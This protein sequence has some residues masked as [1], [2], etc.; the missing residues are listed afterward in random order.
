MGVWFW[1]AYRLFSTSMGRS[2]IF[3]HLGPSVGKKKCTGKQSRWRDRTWGKGRVGRWKCN[4]SLGKRYLFQ[5]ETGQKSWCRLSSIISSFQRKRSIGIL[6]IKLLE[7]CKPPCADR[8]SSRICFWS[9]KEKHKSW[10]A[11][12]TVI[13]VTEQK[14][15]AAFRTAIPVRGSVPKPRN[16]LGAGDRELF[17]W[18]QTW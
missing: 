5:N 6:R 15:L 7:T 11:R 8:W 4:K 16:L 18:P 3:M 1:G 14:H 2:F 10:T 13:L 9:L 12:G 17:P